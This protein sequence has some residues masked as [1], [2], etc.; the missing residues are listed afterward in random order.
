MFTMMN[1]DLVACISY[2]D[3]SDIG[4]LISDS[5][6]CLALYVKIADRL[7]TALPVVQDVGSY[8]SH[9]RS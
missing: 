2:G 9:L 7:W 1:N 6:F 3:Q 5:I 4:L 8:Y